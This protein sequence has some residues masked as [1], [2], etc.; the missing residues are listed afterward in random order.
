MS[1]RI[2]SF[3][4]YTFKVQGH[5]HAH[6]PSMRGENDAGVLVVTKANLQR[7]VHVS[8][9]RSTLAFRRSHFLRTSAMC[10]LKLNDAGIHSSFFR[11]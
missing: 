1:W 6:K 7:H 2:E 10:P 9:G 3:A 8:D 4:K 5:P 11:R